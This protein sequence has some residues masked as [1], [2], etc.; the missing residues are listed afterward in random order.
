MKIRVRRGRYSPPLMIASALLALTLGGVGWAS[1]CNPGCVTSGA[2]ACGPG[3]ALTFLELDGNLGFNSLTGA[4]F[5][6][7]NSQANPSGCLPPDSGTNL[8]TCTGTG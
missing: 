1:I 7:A 6:W 2:P 8:I 4:S 5:D 3:G